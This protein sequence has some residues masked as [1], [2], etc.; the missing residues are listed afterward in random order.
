MRIYCDSN[1]FRKAK[2]TSNQFSEPVFNAMEALKDCFLFLF[3]EAHLHDLA[4]S[5]EHYRIEDLTMMERYV[6]NNYLS[7]DHVYK[8]FGFLL[9]TPLEAYTSI[10]F[11]AFDRVLDDPHAYISELFSSE[12]AQP[13]ASI[14]KSLFDM[15]LFD[16]SNIELPA[17]AP[18]YQKMVEQFKGAKSIN[19]FLKKLNGIGTLMEKKGEFQKLRSAF[20]TYIDRDDYSYDTWS[21]EFD[22][23]MKETVFN[24][25]FSEMV[26]LTIA[27]ADK[28]DEYV[29]FINTYTQLEFLGVTQEKVG[30]QNKI[31]KNSFW[32]IHRDATH[33]YYG[34]KADYFVTDDSGMLTKAFITYKLLGINTQVLSVTDF[35]NKSTMLLKNE[36]NLNTFYKGINYTIKHG[37]IIRQSLLEDQK[38]IKLNYP[39]FNYFNRMQVNADGNLVLFKSYENPYGIMYAEIDLLIAKCNKLWGEFIVN[40]SE[41]YKEVY[42]ELRDSTFI[43]TWSF[44]GSA[45]T[46]TYEL[47][48]LGQRII[49]MTIWFGSNNS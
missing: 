3:S 26:S 37:F 6:K 18:E 10:D 14:I 41:Y 1:I 23:K 13:Y 38:V 43:R 48:T 21:F 19:D 22:Q 11:N 28:N 45:V 20:S 29:N 32:D 17:V 34:G 25:S 40:N 16:P 44:Q 49:A 35:V 4:K 27:D 36:D 12:E 30:K 5:A 24:K 15:P 2:Q 31:K 8:T 42:Q 7:R 47:N 33:A 9:A 39:V 46:L